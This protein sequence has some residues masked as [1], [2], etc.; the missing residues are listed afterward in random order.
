MALLYTQNGVRREIG[1]AVR[2]AAA[3][4]AAF[5]ELT[6]ESMVTRIATLKGRIADVAKMIADNDTSIA[7]LEAE[8]DKRRSFKLEA[9]GVLNNLERVQVAVEDS[10]AN[11]A[12]FTVTPID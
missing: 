6:G 5:M 1:I 9:E 3:D 11:M 4:F 8:L 2:T 10:T 12:N 7:Q